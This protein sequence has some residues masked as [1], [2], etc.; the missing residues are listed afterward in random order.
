MHFFSSSVGATT[1]LPQLS[2][3]PIQSHLNPTTLVGSTGRV[4]HY[5]GRVGD[6]APIESSFIKDGSAPATARYSKP[7]AALHWTC[8]EK[9]SSKE[10]I[11][12]FVT[13]IVNNKVKTN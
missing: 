2:F 13:I 9:K 7:T 12:K 10:V 6:L 3:N 5:N 1:H 11:D 4:R 8:Q